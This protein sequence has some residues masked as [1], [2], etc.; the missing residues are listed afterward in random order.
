MKILGAI[1]LLS[2]ILIFGCADMTLDEQ[3]VDSLGVRAG[4]SL[5]GGLIVSLI[6]GLPILGVIHLIFC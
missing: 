2:T 1:F 4:L 5:I 3:P 6:V